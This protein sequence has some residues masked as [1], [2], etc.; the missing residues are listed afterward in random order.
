MK[1]FVFGFASGIAAVFVIGFIGGFSVM[2]T[3]LIAINADTPPPAWEKS[4]AESAVDASV[5]RHA[6]PE[7]NPLPVTDDNLKTGAEIY[8]AECARCHGQAKGRNSAFG[9]SFYPPVPQ[10]PGHST[11]HSEAELFWIVKH[12]IRNTSMPAWGKTL[13]DNDIWAVV[14]LV[15]RFDSL[16]P[17][18]MAELS[19]RD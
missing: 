13:S 15:K 6:S 16:P 8:R 7:P 19:K 9:A 17:S 10:L 1:K 5:A 2:K 3:G 4:L 11:D 14:S 12:G 18:V